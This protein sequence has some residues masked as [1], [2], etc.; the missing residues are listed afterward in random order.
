MENLPAKILQLTNTLG[1]I[2]KIAAGE[3]QAQDFP[4][5]TDYEELSSNTQFI[6]KRQPLIEFYRQ[7]FQT[8]PK[9]LAINQ[10][11]VQHL[12]L[13]EL[14]RGFSFWNQNP[15]AQLLQELSDTFLPKK[16]KTRLFSDLQVDMA[17]WSQS[18]KTTNFS[19]ADW[20]KLK[21]TILPSFAPK[22]KKN[23]PTSILPPIVWQWIME[24]LKQ[25]IKQNDEKTVADTDILLS[26]L[27]DFV[28]QLLDYQVVNENSKLIFS[29]LSDYYWLAYQQQKNR[30]KGKLIFAQTLHL[31]SPSQQQSSLFASPN[32]YLNWGEEI[33]LQ[34]HSIIYFNTFKYNNNLSPVSTFWLNRTKLSYN[35]PAEA[36]ENL[37]IWRWASD[38]VNSQGGLLVVSDAQWLRSPQLRDFRQKLSE[39]FKQIM[40]LEL[41]DNQVVS[42]LFK[43]KSKDNEPNAQIQYLAVPNE[44]FWFKNNA[45]GLDFQQINPYDGD[46]LEQMASDF[47]ELI[48]LL[49]N[50]VKLGRS[51]KAIFKWF[52]NF[53]TLDNQEVSENLL[54][55]V[56]E[57]MIQNSQIYLAN[58]QQNA[59]FFA[60][61]GEGQLDYKF[62]KKTL[63]L[64]YFRQAGDGQ[65][66]ENI[67][68]WG[69]NQFRKQYET[70]WQAQA[71]SNIYYLKK[72][73]DFSEFE[74]C[75]VDES[76]AFEIR[77]L[78]LL[79]DNTLEINYLFK[80]INQPE[81]KTEEIFQ[82][83]NK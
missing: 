14:F 37:A 42:L 54:P 30:Q 79:A 43:Q 60:W 51:K 15:I 53:K 44:E 17:A 10:L 2:V 22:N 58:F 49:D 18:L 47:A 83:F 65:I 12:I 4:Q 63:V 46:W 61:A 28:L 62:L 71:Q 19:L 56:S 11:I 29:Q 70:P 31:F 38:Q 52:E 76:L 50:E 80:T 73:L 1:A 67:S 48:P 68:N 41:P 75:Q 13:A 78:T 64:P 8:S 25:R 59:G 40:L 69:L 24:F 77:R 34:K 82:K 45:L 74:Q 57:K 55:Q 66:V 36:L 3:A 26:E 39:E 33:K 6:Q 81:A 20:E 5:L 35:P 32:P 27:D 7:A 21:L 72:L 16:H 9:P 23:N